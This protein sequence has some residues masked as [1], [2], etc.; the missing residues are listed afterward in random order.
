MKPRSLVGPVILIGI[1]ALFLV[2]NLRPEL[3]PLRLLADF[4]PYLLIGWGLLRLFEVLYWASRDRPLPLSGVSGG[5]WALVVIIC[6]IGSGTWAARRHVP[7]ADIGRISVRGM[8]VFGQPYDYPVEE[9]TVKV[10]ASP[11]IVIENLRGNVRVIGTA[12]DELRVTGRKTIRA[13]QQEDANRANTEATLEISQQGAQVIVRTNQERVTGERRISVDLELTVPKG[14]SISGRG[15]RAGEYDI[16]DLTGEVDITSDRAD[17]RL[18]N[19]GGKVKLDLRGSNRIRAA[20]VK[21]NVEVAGRGENVEI[22]DVAG[23]VVLNGSYSGDLNL[24]R[25]AKSVKFQSPKTEFSVARLPGSVSMDLGNLTG[26]DLTGPIVLRSGSKD[27][28]FERFTGEL[29]LDVQ[30]GEITL[31]PL[32]AAIAPMT[33]RT[34]TGNVEVVLPEATRFSL[35]AVTKRGDVNN[36]FGEVISSASDDSGRILRKAGGGPLISVNSD[37]GSITIRKGGVMSRPVERA[38]AEDPAAEAPPRE[39]RKVKTETF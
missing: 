8:E 7:W 33:I 10:G 34:R 2:N 26:E 12:T 30:R 32:S 39:G 35:E 28:R 23:E 25:I 15:G 3:S 29:D 18:E 19:I 13:M 31:L 6:L 14:A 17:V 5:E 38:E 16:A 22:E 21:N 1:G 36:S 4:W 9:Q 11:R 20:R 24:R 27:V 37:R